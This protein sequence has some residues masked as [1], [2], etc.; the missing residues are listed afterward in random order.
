[1]NFVEVVKYG[2]QILGI[3]FILWMSIYQ[4]TRFLKSK[5]IL[6]TQKMKL[7]QQKKEIQE[8]EK[9]DINL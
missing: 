1:M 6:K 8:D 2:L 7:K 9:T 5:G 4:T 3:G